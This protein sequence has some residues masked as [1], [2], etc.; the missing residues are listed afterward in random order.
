VFGCVFL[1]GAIQEVLGD[2]SYRDTARR[3]E[4]TIAQT[5]ELDRT[6]DVLERAFKLVDESEV[7]VCEKTPDT[8]AHS[9]T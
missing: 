8:D 1:S 6:A 2:P 9:P 7:V 3:F 4:R 5:H